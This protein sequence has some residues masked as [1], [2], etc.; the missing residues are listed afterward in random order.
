M[1]INGA[2]GN[3]VKY[4]SVQ[5]IVSAWTSVVFRLGYTAFETTVPKI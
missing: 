3:N 5:G 1:I 2:G 4:V